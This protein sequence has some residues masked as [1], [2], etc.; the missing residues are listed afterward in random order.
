M[1]LVSAMTSSARVCG[2]YIAGQRRVRFAAPCANEVCG[3]Y[4]LR[5]HVQERDS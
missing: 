4:G 3:G 1:A 5:L 2:A